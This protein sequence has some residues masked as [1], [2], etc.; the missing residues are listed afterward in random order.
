MG[1]WYVPDIC[2]LDVESGV[3]V[4]YREVNDT[5]VLAK[6][7]HVNFQCGVSLV[8]STTAGLLNVLTSLQQELKGETSGL[9]G[10]WNGDHT[11]DFKRPN[12]TILP[13][14][15][16]MQEIHYQFG[17]TCKEQKHLFYR[18]IWKYIIG[19]VF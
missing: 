19:G 13:V 18:L 3:T 5:G 4:L 8:V 1:D 6:K 9:Y 12:G 17:Q 14:N 16:T 7:I 15:A 11:D 10:D 2:L